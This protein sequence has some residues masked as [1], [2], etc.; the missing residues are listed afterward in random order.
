MDE[1]NSIYCDLNTPICVLKQALN[2]HF[3]A[4]AYQML[5]ITLL[6][7]VLSE[8]TSFSCDFQQIIC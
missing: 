6:R 1:E 8:R 4:R 7:Q 5:L 3:M 2:K